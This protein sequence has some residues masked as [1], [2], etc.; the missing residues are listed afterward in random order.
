MRAD[1]QWGESTPTG[2]ILGPESPQILDAEALIQAISTEFG[3]RAA[4]GLLD[5]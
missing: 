3:R 1:H 5:E 4:L 2:A